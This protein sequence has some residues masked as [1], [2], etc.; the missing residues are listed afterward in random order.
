[1]IKGLILVFILFIEE[2][3]CSSPILDVGNI[4]KKQVASGTLRFN[5]LLDVFVFDSFEF[6]FSVNWE[7]V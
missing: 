6:G 4:N 5:L 2:I 1:L 7:E 3:L